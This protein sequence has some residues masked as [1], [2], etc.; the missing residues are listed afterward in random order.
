MTPPSHDLSPPQEKHTK[1]KKKHENICTKHET[2]WLFSL[3]PPDTEACE[4]E[5]RAEMF[6]GQ[7]EGLMLRSGTT[8]TK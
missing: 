6:T 8:G 7:T 2:T 1:K 4:S 3:K 5:F